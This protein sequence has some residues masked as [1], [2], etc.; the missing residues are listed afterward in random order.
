M[1]VLL[2]DRGRAVTISPEG[3]P[4]IDFERRRGDVNRHGENSPRLAQAWADYTTTGWGEVAFPD[5]FDFNLTFAE[6]PFVSY[7]YK[8]IRHQLSPDTY[9]ELV[10]D[11][12]VDTRFP[13]CHGGV[14]D[15]QMNSRGFYIGA[16]M[17][18]TIQTQDPWITTTYPDPNYVIQH[19]F[20]FAAMGIKDLPD[21][22]VDE[23]REG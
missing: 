9:P 19:H 7:S 3:N 1:E 10:D 21:Y 23:D 20:T 4:W 2:H 8:V 6:R 11:V 18:V 22:Q 17:F 16:W 13:R 5:C 15:W 14:Y 12:L